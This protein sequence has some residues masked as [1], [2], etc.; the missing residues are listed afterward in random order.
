MG[1]DFPQ[2]YENVI[3]RGLC[4]ACGTCVGACPVNALDWVFEDD[5]PVPR[6]V[7]ECCQC[8]NCNAVCPGA[9][10]NIPELERLIFNRERDEQIPDLGIYAGSFQARAVDNSVRSKGASGGVVTSLLAFALEENVIDCALV[11]GFKQHMP[12]RTEPRLAVNR[13]EL[14][15]AAQS[16]YAA[17]PVNALLG[18]AHQKG[19]RRIAIVGLPCQV[20]G[21]RKLQFAGAEKELAKSVK[22]VIGLFCASQFYFEGTRHLLVEQLGIK[23]LE[24]IKKFSYR[25]G[26]WPGHMVVE[27]KDNRKLTLDRHQYMYHG[28]MPCFKRDRCEMCVDWSSELADI[29]VGDYWSPEMKPGIEMGTSSC[30]VRTSTGLELFDSANVKGCIE[31]EKLDAEILAAGI[32]YELKK[33][34]AAFRLKQ[35]QR[36]GWPVPHYHRKTDYKPFSKELHLA[37]STSSQNK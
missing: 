19:Y 10:V 8:G 14:L 2:L 6:L 35:R 5:E 24:E 29:S 23:N 33:H 26:D 15:A 1:D 37:P 32:G 27:L 11:A 12:W 31:K 20:H 17:V 16:K 13:Q 25:G 7:G 21:L 4:T 22:L 18:E 34:S 28:L 3:A 9:D 36:Y 30:L